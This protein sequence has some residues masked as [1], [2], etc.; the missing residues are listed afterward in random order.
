M[1]TNSQ[2]KR[3]FPLAQTSLTLGWAE[4]F[5]TQFYMFHSWLTHSLSTDTDVSSKMS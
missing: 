4:L 2:G 5:L 1:K 3:L